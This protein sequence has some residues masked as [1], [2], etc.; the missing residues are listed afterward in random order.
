[1][2]QPA[3]PSRLAT[4]LTFGERRTPRY[5]SYPTAPHFTTDVG[6]PTWDRWL[7]A[8]DPGDPVSLYLHVPYC[9]E[10]CWYCGC[11]TRATRRTK[12]LADYLVVLLAEIDALAARLPARM[13]VSHIAFGGGTPTLMT[14]DQFE[15]VMDRLR[16]HFDIEAD[17]EIAVEADPRSLSKPLAQAMGRAGVTRASLGLQTFD[18]AIQAAINRIQSLELVETAFERL[19][20]AGVSAINADLLYGLPGQTVSSAAKSARIAARLEPSRLAVFGYAHVPH[21]KAHQRLIPEASLPGA[22]ERIAQGEAMGAVLEASGYEMIGIDHFARP[23]DPMARMARAGTL[24]RNFQG[25]TTDRA[26]TI[27]GLGASSI[28]RTPFGYAQNHPE[29]GLWRDAVNA[30]IS[31]VVRG[32][33]IDDEDRMRAAIIESIMCRFEA[34][35]AAIAHAFGQPEPAAELGELERAGVLRRDGARILVNPDFRPLARLVAAAFD[36]RLSAGP[37]KHSLSV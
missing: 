8:L 10:L 32:V 18:P 28:S 14:A 36:A 7:A 13:A 15:A 33:E 20:E 6:A 9:A 16:A 3:P 19:H 37:A 4:L 25:Y 31:P 23:D 17:A 27:L 29:V 30:G 5:T 22:A 11:N 2:T 1:M 21:M 34:D 26:R 24:R 12:P 35:P